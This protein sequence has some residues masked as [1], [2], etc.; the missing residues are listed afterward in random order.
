[1]DTLYLTNSN[2]KINLVSRTELWFKKYKYCVRVP[3]EEATALR[4]L[5][6]NA[7]DH[8]IDMRR[9]WGRRR[10][11]AINH[12]TNWVN[13]N[14][15]RIAAETVQRLHQCCDFLITDTR[16]RKL[17]LIYNTVH[18]YTTDYDLIQDFLAQSFVSAESATISQCELVG[19]PG[20][21]QLQ[22]PNHQFRTYFKHV[23]LTDNSADNLRRFLQ[24][25]E[26]LRISPALTEWILAK[27]NRMHDYYFVDH[28]NSG[29]ISMLNLIVPGVIRKTLSI[30]ATK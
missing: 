23:T 17:V 22:D 15:K 25:Q 28:D 7:I 18:L 27:G 10:R 21:I 1:M 14:D 13:W 4:E 9:S 8:V 6:H 3:M 2:P 20:T 12:G 24:V 16:D 11:Q 19:I 30:V 26:D 29:V 5:N